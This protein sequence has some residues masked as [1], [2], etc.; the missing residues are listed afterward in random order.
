MSLARALVVGVVAIALLVALLCGP[1]VVYAKSTCGCNYDSEEEYFT[2]GPI[3]GITA[4]T[5]FNSKLEDVLPPGVTVEEVLK[6][7]I[8][9]SREIYARIN[10]FIIRGV[11]P[12][13]WFVYYYLG[14]LPRGTGVMLRLVWIPRCA[15]LQ[16]SLCDLATR[17]CQS[18]IV[19]DG[20]A[21]VFFITPRSSHYVLIIRNL[22]SC[23]VKYCGYLIIILPGFVKVRAEVHGVNC[24]VVYK[25]LKPTAMGPIGQEP[26]EIA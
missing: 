17:M 20:S 15:P 10:A 14:Y 1:S 9:I 19:R 18:V 24:T 13:Y 16:I 23:T 11:I 8:D 25:E 7:A 22:S 26:I 21:W 3:V 5:E 2:Y 4:V 6:K 12:P